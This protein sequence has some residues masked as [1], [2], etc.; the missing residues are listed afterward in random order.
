MIYEM[1]SG[2][3]PFKVRNKNK[4]EKLQMITDM[5]IAMMPMFGE[6]AKNLL[7]GLLQRNPRQRIGS[8][9]D[10]ADEIKN[11]PFFADIDWEALS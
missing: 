6:N 5:D 11:H 2:I 9:S 8:S 1:L 3:N 4:F 7:E 10:G